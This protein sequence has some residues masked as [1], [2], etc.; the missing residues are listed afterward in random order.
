MDAGDSSEKKPLRVKNLNIS[1]KLMQ[2][3][4]QS[5]NP[6]EKYL[7]ASLECQLNRGRAAIECRDFHFLAKECQGR[8]QEEMLKAGKERRPVH[9][10]PDLEIPPVPPAKYDFFK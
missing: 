4:R 8:L 1:N 7:R 10:D 9:F 2:D 6:C 5:L 3:K